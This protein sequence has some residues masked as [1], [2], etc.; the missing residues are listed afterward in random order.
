MDRQP[1][2]ILR[3]IF[4]WIPL[5]RGV[6]ISVCRR[7]RNI[8]K[9]QTILPKRSLHSACYTIEQHLLANKPINVVITEGIDQQLKLI[10]DDL[11][12]T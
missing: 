10:Y 7:F 11:G 2:D 1:D 9:N 3:L 8:C 12:I 6:L 5:Y 4:A